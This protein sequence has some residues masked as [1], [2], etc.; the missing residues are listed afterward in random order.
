MLPKKPTLILQMIFFFAIFIVLVVLIMRQ[1]HSPDPWSRLDRYI[2]ALLA[3]SLG[4]AAIQTALSV[5]LSPSSDVTHEFFGLTF[6][7]A[8]SGWISLLGFLELLAFA[9]YAHWRLVPSLIHP[10]VQAVGILLYASAFVCMLRV[11]NYLAAN[12]DSAFQQHRLL[13]DGP[14]RRIQHPRYLA[15]ALSRVAFVLTIGSIIA[16]VLFLGWIL[17]IFRRIQ[18]EEAHLRDGF[19]SAY[20]DYASH[21]SRLLPGIY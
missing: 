11:D 9:D 2:I 4:M 3:F 16:W 14:Y 18:R 20:A 7:K 1:W 21:R 6:D 10:A 13:S 12:F 5:R 8:M 19:G 17:V 15:L